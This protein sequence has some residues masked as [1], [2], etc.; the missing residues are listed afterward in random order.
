MREF[1]GISSPLLCLPTAFRLI[2]L[3]DKLE[4]DFKVVKGRATA[5]DFHDGEGKTDSA[6]P[7][8]SSGSHLPLLYQPASTRQNGVLLNIVYIITHKSAG[9]ASPGRLAQGHHL[10]L[11]LHQCIRTLESEENR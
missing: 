9:F 1:L 4:S 3:V 7:T 6:R 10:P 5:C 2:S 11:R 8:D